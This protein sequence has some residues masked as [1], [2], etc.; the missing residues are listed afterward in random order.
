VE[1]SRRCDA[2]SLLRR[3]ARRKAADHARNLAGTCTENLHLRP[4]DYDAAYCDYQAA[5]ELSDTA[6]REALRQYSASRAVRERA[7]SP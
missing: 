1:V 4:E 3:S 6:R 5:H 2:I 7:Q